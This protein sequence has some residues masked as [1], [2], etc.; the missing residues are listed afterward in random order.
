MSSSPSDA[1]PR[2]LRESLSYEPVELAFGTSGLRG[3]VRDITCLEAYVNTRGFLAACAREGERRGDAGVCLAGDLRSST[4]R[5]MR[6]VARA[7]AD[8]GLPLVHLGRIPSPA[9]MA[10]AVRRGL[11]SVMVTGSHIPF[12]RNGIKFNT[13]VGEVTKAEEP[14]ILAEVRKAREREYARPAGESIFDSN[15]ALPSEHY[16][17]LPP[18][19]EEARSDYIRRYTSAFPRGL[20]AGRR[21]LVYQ[22]SAVGRDILVEVLSSLGVDVVSV[23]RSESFVAVDTEAVSESMLADIQALADA[24][25]GAAL[26]AV[27]STD[28]DSDRPLV[29]AVDGGRLRFVPGDIL[30]MVAAN[31]LGVRS[32][33]VPVSASDALDLFLGPRGVRLT[34]TRIGSPHVIAAMVGSGAEV[35]WEANGGFLSA[36]PLAVPD[37]GSLGPLATR[38]ALLPI[39]ALLYASL[40]RGMSVAELLSQLPSRFGRSS[41]L[42]PFPRDRALAIVAALSPANPDIVEA[43]FETPEGRQPHT[44]VIRAGGT[45]GPDVA[46]ESLAKELARIRGRLEGFFTPRDGFGPVAWINWLDG[47]RVGFANEDVAHVRPSGNAPELRIYALAD[48]PERADAIVA[49]AIAG[50]GIFRRIEAAL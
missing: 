11:P 16:S 41:L 7:V 43:R 46:D 45:T 29:L 50:N 34:R 9:L 37:G 13:G 42:R 19:L 35:G 32:A 23:G 15:G 21:V 44:T 4:E 36:A 20:L 26:D 22:H 5:I 25:G 48:S 38:D 2:T 49:R 30:G 40:G 10:F 28:G 1:R 47:V 17:A 3:L 33:A 24:N 8:E 18:A 27:V 31:F 6:V 39:L 12:D 14:A